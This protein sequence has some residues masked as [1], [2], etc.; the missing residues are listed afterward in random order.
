MHFVDFNELTQTPAKP[1]NSRKRAHSQRPPKYPLVV[2]GKIKISFDCAKKKIKKLNLT[3]LNIILPYKKI[4]L[5]YFV[6]FK[7]FD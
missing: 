1:I 6:L 7:I 4:T 2:N 5:R 3:R